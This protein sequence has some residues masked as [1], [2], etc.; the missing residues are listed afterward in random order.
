[1]Q[2]NICI[3]FLYL[4]WALSGFSIQTRC[5]IILWM[6]DTIIIFTK[7]F[8][9]LPFFGAYVSRARICKRY[10]EPKN[11]DAKGVWS[12]VPW[13]ERSSRKGKLHEK[14]G[15][16]KRRREGLEEVLH[17]EKGPE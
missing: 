4:D 14:K 15:L 3:E 1:M 6:I 9:N 11:I 5:E 16:E 10:K 8:E 13:E 2:K 12:A 7:F 17:E